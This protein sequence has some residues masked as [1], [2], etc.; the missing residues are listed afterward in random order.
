MIPSQ[1]KWLGAGLLLLVVAAGAYFKG[2]HQVE[3]E[4]QKDKTA[5]QVTYDAQVAETN[6]IQGEWDKVK[7]NAN[8]WKIKAETAGNDA[9]AVARRLRAYRASCSALPSTASGPS[10]PDAAGGEP[11]DPQGIDAATERHFAACA[12]DSER[13][14]MWRV[15][16]SQLRGSQ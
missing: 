9:A 16:Y 8:D 10:D 11:S 7:V 3:L 6:R 1:Y 15:F 13:L 12:R 2:R 4:W 14:D 5:W